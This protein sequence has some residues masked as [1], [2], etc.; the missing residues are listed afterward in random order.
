MPNPKKRGIE[1]QRRGRNGGIFEIMIFFIKYF[2]LDIQTVRLTPP[3][4]TFRARTISGPFSLGAS[5][6]W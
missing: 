2:Q 3:P 5:P 1:T 4:P 6:G